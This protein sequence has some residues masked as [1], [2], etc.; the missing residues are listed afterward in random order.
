[1]WG[2]IERVVLLKNILFRGHD[3]LLDHYLM[4]FNYN[5]IETNERRR[6]F[7]KMNIKYLDNLKIIV[8]MVEVQESLC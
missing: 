3:N 7:Y 2:H 5:L 6:G 1:L 4:V 8:G